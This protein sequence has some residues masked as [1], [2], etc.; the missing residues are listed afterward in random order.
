MRSTYEIVD[1]ACLVR[2]KIWQDAGAPLVV[3]VNIS[4]SQF[5]R[6]NIIELVSTAL[7]R[8]QL[9]PSLLEI[10]LTESILIHDTETI[11][12]VLSQLKQ[13]GIKLSIDDFGTGYSN[14]SYLRMLHL[15]KIK[16]DQSFITHMA[17]NENQP[18]IRV[19]T[20]DLAHN[21]GLKVIA[22]GV[23]TA[24]AVELLEEFGCDQLQ[25]YHFGKPMPPELF[26]NFIK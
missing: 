26:M 24:G 7:E 22:E 13:L 4:A 16:I 2:L 9:D 1:A 10:E 3:A 25:G 11:R 18:D 14:L 12:Q 20:I 23:E 21:L 6:G 5:K 8:H 15:D 17:I 19:L